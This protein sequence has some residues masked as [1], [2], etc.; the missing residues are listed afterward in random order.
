[1]DWTFK[2]DNYRKFKIG[3]NI[4]LVPIAFVS[5]HSETLV[6][7]DIEYKELADKNGC[8]NYLR[9]PALGTNENFIK[10]MSNLIIN[11]EHNSFNKEFFP[12]KLKCPNQFKNVRV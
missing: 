11:K 10:A 5:E 8:K 4:A 9:V 3:K 2:E 12:P 1:M 6:E 7:L